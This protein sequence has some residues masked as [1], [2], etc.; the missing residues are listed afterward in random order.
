[1]TKQSRRCPSNLLAELATFPQGRPPECHPMSTALH[2]VHLIRAKRVGQD[3]RPAAGTPH[4]RVGR[5]DRETEFGTPPRSSRRHTSGC[6]GA[7]HPASVQVT[8]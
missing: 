4:L 7:R 3:A 8:M 2:A 1:M 5:L 6:Q